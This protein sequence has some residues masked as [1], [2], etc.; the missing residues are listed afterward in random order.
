MP[1]PHWMLLVTA[2]V[3]AVS[4][5]SAQQVDLDKVDRIQRQIGSRLAW[6]QT[7]L[8]SASSTKVHLATTAFETLGEM[9]RGLL[10]ASLT[11]HERSV[12]RFRAGV[13]GGVHR[14]SCSCSIQRILSR[15]RA[16][17]S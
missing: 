13:H 4:S 8:S 7:S 14:P 3:F 12:Q 10:L 2:A 6:N 1:K 9:D 15:I 17:F 16:A 11:I 5:A